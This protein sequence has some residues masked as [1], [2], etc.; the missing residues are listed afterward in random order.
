MVL[1]KVEG[2][3]VGLKPCLCCMLSTS[4]PM[5]NLICV[6]V[7]LYLYMY[8]QL[9]QNV[10]GPR[11]HEVGQHPHRN[12]CT[13]YIVLNGCKMPTPFGMSELDV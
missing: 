4:Q 3:V 8:I 5:L 1:K 10:V 13:R 12:I 7:C 9:H 11:S 2:A 6:C